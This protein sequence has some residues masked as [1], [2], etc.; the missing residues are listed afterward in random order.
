MGLYYFQGN[1]PIPPPQCSHRT[2]W[3]GNLIPSWFHLLQQSILPKTYLRP[4]HFWRH[5]HIPL[6]LS[7]QIK[8]STT[9]THKY[10]H[11][12][13]MSPWI[14]EL[15]HPGWR[16]WWT[17]T[18]SRLY[19]TLYWPRSHCRDHWWLWLPNQQKCR[20]SPPNHTEHC[21]H[22]NSFQW[23]PRRPMV[24]LLLIHHMEHLTPH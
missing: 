22:P 1:P 19:V 4:H 11:S 5:H 23:K 9:P 24:F 10:L 8:A 17:W 12:V 7:H 3:S 18:I 15:H 21:L 13:L 20:T 14:K 6:W 2:T 16:R